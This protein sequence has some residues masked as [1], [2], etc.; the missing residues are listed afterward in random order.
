M[1]FI[2]F[3]IDD[4]GELTEAMDALVVEGGGWVN[5]MPVT[6]GQSEL[7]SARSVPGMIFGQMGGRGPAMPKITWTAP[8]TRRKRV[9]PPQLG[10]EHPAGSRA[11]ALLA[12]AGHPVPLGWVVLQDHSLRG[13]VLAVGPAPDAPDPTSPATPATVITWAVRAAEVL[14]GHQG[15]DWRAQVF[16]SG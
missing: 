9:D 4:L 14:A 12:E 6:A 11:E 13:L 8:E 16:P 15:P 5:A 2:R 7:S 10:I 1:T 3:T